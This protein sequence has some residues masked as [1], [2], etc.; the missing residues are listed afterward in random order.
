MEPK[1]K[2]KKRKE[3]IDLLCPEADDSFESIKEI[4]ES[5]ENSDGNFQTT[6]MVIILQVQT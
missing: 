6:Q 1:F 5:I 4:T 2:L 3:N